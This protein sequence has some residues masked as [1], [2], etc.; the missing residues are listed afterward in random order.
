ML[1]NLSDRTLLL[2][3]AVL[4]A[5]A[6]W[7]TI[8]YHNPDEHTQIWEFA[9][10]KLGYTDASILSWEFAEKMRPGLQPFLAYCMVIGADGL[11][12]T[13]PFVQTFL[14]RLL[15]G[16]VALFVYWEWSKWLQRD[17]K[18]PASIRWM[19]IGLLFFWLMPYL[20]VRF[21][22]ENAAALSFFGGLLVLLHSIDK[23]KN[24]FTGNMVVAGLLLGLSFFFRYQIAFAGI[25]LGAWLFFQ[26][27]L[28]WP[29]WAALF[30]GALLAISIGLAT[31][32]WLYGEWV[33]APYNYYFSNIVEGKAAGFG[34][35]PVWWYL[36]EMPIALIPPLSLVLVAFFF[37][38]L[39]QKPGHIFTWCLVPFILAHSLVAHKEVRF[40]YPMALPFFFMAAT[41]WQYVQ[42]NF[43]IK[44]WMTKFLAFC[45][46]LNAILLVIR[47][48]IPAKEIV[49]YAQFLWTWQDKHPS[50]T[51]YFVKKE[52]KNHYPLPISFYEHHAQR[53][54]SWYTMP[55]YK[56]DTSSLRPGD[57]M[58]FTEVLSS[59]PAPPPGYRIKLEFLYYPHWLLKHNI[60]NWLS[61]T[62][63]W[64]IY[65]LEIAN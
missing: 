48:F 9:N 14:T 27:Q 42:E 31:D 32:F 35:M 7:F 43:G 37:V 44:N 62:L 46:Y 28:K 52:P 50:S 23:Q 24:K 38:G 8:G 6:A 54:Q 13:N 10:Y 2:L 40:M 11:G 17:L 57:L 61:R 58:V 5:I 21:T 30:S 55:M 4:C 65:S 60:N 56:N 20:N 49:V 16:L 45:L 47:I 34:V 41:G 3:G 59:P 22:S 53:Q 26:N 33:F 15:C 18:N 64:E 63:I 39:W 29:I 12:I 36:T 19:R 25:G 1:P 51:V